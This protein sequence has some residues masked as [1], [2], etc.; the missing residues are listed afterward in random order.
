MHKC[1]YHHHY[2]HHHHFS[3]P[4]ILFCLLSLL[5]M[6][7]YFSAMFI[8]YLSSLLWLLH[9][10]KVKKN[11]N[12]W[13]GSHLWRYTH[14]TWFVHHECAEHYLR[15]K[16]RKEIHTFFFIPLMYKIKVKFTIKEIFPLVWNVAWFKSDLINV[17]L[18]LL[19]PHVKGAVNHTGNRPKVMWC[20]TSTTC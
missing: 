15:N 5:L 16:K 3:V 14:I 4:L 13:K 20:N 6:R 10:G 2:H 9:L 1:K 17:P 19:L 12:L 7:C 18:A 11:K 8:I